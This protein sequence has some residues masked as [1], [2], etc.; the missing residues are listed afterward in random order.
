MALPEQCVQW[1]A[2][3]GLARSVVYPSLTSSTW[4]DT[5]EPSSPFRACPLLLL[6]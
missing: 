2:R 5:R 4:I 1:S 6:R 3:A